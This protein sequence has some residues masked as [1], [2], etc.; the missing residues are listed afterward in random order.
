MAAIISNLSAAEAPP[1][2]RTGDTI[3]RVGQKYLFVGV[4]TIATRVTPR[5]YRTEI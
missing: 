5:V 4:A 1:R 2:A 3:K